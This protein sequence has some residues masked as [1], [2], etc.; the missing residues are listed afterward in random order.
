MTHAYARNTDWIDPNIFAGDQISGSISC[1]SARPADS[2]IKLR[3]KILPGK[4]SLTSEASED[5]DCLIQICALRYVPTTIPANI[6]SLLASAP[7]THTGPYIKSWL[8]PCYRLT[9]EG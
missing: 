8:A 6:T 5:K 1:S 9:A 4:N 2:S 3:A 7:R